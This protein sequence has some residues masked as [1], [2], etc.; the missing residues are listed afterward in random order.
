MDTEKLTHVVYEHPGS[1]FAEESGRVVDHRDPQRAADSAPETAFAFTF[2]EIVTSTVVVD[3]EEVV[4]RSK[5][6]NVSGR[7][8]LGGELLTYAQV[9][10]LDG[11]HR[12][13]LSNM[14]GNGWDPIIRCRF[15]NFQPF[16]DGDKIVTLVDA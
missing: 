11:D 5:P 3:G 16:R 14:R 8:Y 7:Y 1:F 10:A 9:E 2:H 13:L 6:L 4:T 15:G 12:I